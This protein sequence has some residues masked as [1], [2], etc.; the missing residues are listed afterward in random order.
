[1]LRSAG[2]RGVSGPWGCGGVYVVADELRW[3]DG[4][5]VILTDDMIEAPCAELRSIVDPVA[6]IDTDGVGVLEPS[7]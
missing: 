7:R 4:V 2:T 6:S 3:L 1:V 5:F